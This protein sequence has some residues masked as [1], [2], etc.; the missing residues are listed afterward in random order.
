MQE[1]PAHHDSK[2][3]KPRESCLKIAPHNVMI[4]ACC[5][6]RTVIDVLKKLWVRNQLV[7]VMALAIV[8]GTRH[9]PQEKDSRRSVT[10]AYEAA[11]MVK[12][13]R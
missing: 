4:E 2:A 12:L 10:P 5:A 11:L 6:E 7:K 8:Y 13:P 9:N 3:R 1:V